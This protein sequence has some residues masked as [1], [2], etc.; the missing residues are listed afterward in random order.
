MRP[1]ALLLVL[2]AILVCCAS[3]RLHETGPLGL[4][5]FSLLGARRMWRTA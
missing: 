1:L 3:W 4:V 5:A 2:C